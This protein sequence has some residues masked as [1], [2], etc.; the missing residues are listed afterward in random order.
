MSPNEVFGGMSEIFKSV[1]SKIKTH[2]KQTIVTNDSTSID[3]ETGSA[4]LSNRNENKVISSIK[5]R[6]VSL[7]NQGND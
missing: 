3:F 7:H 1:G 4:K 6:D 2:L 5:S